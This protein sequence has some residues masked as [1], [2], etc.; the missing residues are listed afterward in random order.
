MLILIPTWFSGSHATWWQVYLGEGR[1]LDP[2]RYFIVI[3]NQIGNGLSTSP[4]TTDE[5]PTPGI[6]SEIEEQL[7]DRFGLSQCHVV[8]TSGEEL[9]HDLGSR[10]VRFQ[11]FTRTRHSLHRRRNSSISRDHVPPA[12]PRCR[13]GGARQMDRSSADVTSDPEGPGACV[14]P[15]HTRQPVSRVDRA[16]RV[17][18]GP[19]DG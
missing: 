19:L 7:E 14:L 5:V 16:L 18:T 1:A 12:R 17:T 8:D 9:I 10:T 3:V 4:H 6:F 2:T 11:C 13:A 15:W